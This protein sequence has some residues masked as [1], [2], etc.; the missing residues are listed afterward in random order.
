MVIFGFLQSLSLE[1]RELIYDIIGVSSIII[2]IITNIC[3]GKKFGLTVKI[4]VLFSLATYLGIFLLVPLGLRQ[5]ELWLLHYG[6]LAVFRSALFLPLISWLLAKTMHKDFGLVCSYLTPIFFSCHS[7]ASIGCIFSGCCTGIACSWGFLNPTTGVITF[8]LQLLTM[9]FAATVGIFGFWYN[10]KHNYCAGTQTLSY[11]LIF[12][13]IFRF[14][15]EFFSSSNRLFL[16]LS[17]Y[18]IY[19]LLMIIVGALILRGSKKSLN[20]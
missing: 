14:A 9:F 20:D 3:Y 17:L 1:T 16:K 2:A 12:Y 5:L 8:P 7:I 19:S 4:A 11:S 18:S 15:A 6:S 10:K 13:G